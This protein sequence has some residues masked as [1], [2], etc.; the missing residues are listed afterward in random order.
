MNATMDIKM[1]MDTPEVAYNVV[2]MVG[3][4]QPHVA[5]STFPQVFFFFQDYQNSPN[6]F[7]AFYFLKQ[8]WVP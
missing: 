8:I 6:L 7:E 4:T 5:V 1:E 3:L 2:T